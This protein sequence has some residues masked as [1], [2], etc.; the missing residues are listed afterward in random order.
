LDSSRPAKLR[1]KIALKVK[2]QNRNYPVLLHMQAGIEEVR[3]YEFHSNLRHFYTRIVFGCIYS[4]SNAILYVG[5]KFSH[6]GVKWGNAD[7][8]LLFC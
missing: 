7:G 4:V 1:L 3:N 2:H 8:V 5:I 6:C